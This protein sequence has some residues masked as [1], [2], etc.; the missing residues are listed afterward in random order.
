MRTVKITRAKMAAA[1]MGAAALALLLAAGGCGGD[2]G[3]GGDGQKAPAKKA[4][5]AQAAGAASWRAGRV[6]MDLVGTGRAD[7]VGAIVE[8]RGGVAV[9]AVVVGGLDVQ[10]ARQD[11]NAAA[12]LAAAAV[13]EGAFCGPIDDQGRATGLWV[14]QTSRRRILRPY[15]AGLADAGAGVTMGQWLEGLDAKGRP[16][17]Q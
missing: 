8:V 9:S 15:A 2:G 3:P 1:F 12:G 17:G 6:Q 14:S 16:V 13:A 4:G 5:P 7:P 10:A 11:P